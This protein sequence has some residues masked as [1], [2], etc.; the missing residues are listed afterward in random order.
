MN[1]EDTGAEG[2]LPRGKIDRDQRSD[3]SLGGPLFQRRVAVIIGSDLVHPD[4]SIG[5]MWSPVCHL[6]P[7]GWRVEKYLFL[8]FQPGAAEPQP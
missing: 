4:H 6:R 2:V 1:P 5:D 3:V 8:K 7:G